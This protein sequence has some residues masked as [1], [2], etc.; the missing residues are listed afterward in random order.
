MFIYKFEVSDCPSV[1]T[2]GRPKLCTILF[3]LPEWRNLPF[4]CYFGSLIGLGHLGQ[5]QVS[6]ENF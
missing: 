4:F 1:H 3:L 2:C 6:E 5:I